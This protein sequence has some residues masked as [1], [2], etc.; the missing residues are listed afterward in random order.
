MRANVNWTV[1]LAFLVGFGLAANIAEAQ[2]VI[3]VD[4]DAPAG[5]DGAS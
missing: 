2:S 5:G 1:A 3:F 4:E